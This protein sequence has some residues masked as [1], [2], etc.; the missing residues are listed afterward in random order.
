MKNN[1]T[2]LGR[3]NEALSQQLPESTSIPITDVS[4]IGPFDNTGYKGL[5]T[6]YDV[7][8]N[9]DMNKSYQGRDGLIDWVSMLHYSG[10]ENDYMDL[11]MSMPSSPWSVCYIVATIDSPTDQI[12]QLSLEVAGMCWA[13][14]NDQLILAPTVARQCNM[15]EDTLFV[16]LKKGKNILL[17]KAHYGV[18]PWAFKWQC[19][20]FGDMENVCDS[21]SK[22]TESSDPMIALTAKYTL[23]EIYAA[24]DIDKKLLETTTAI[25]QDRTATIWDKT[26]VKTLINQ[27]LETGSYL[28]IRD[29]KIDYKP[30]ENITPCDTLWPQVPETSKE[31]FVLDTSNES[32]QVE[33]ACKILQG[34][35]NR[36][37]PSLYITHTMYAKHDRQW[38]DEL[39]LE[40]YTSTPIS[41]EEAWKKYSSCIK[42]A[43]IYDGD[44]MDEIGEFRSHMLNQTNVLMMIASLED[45]IPI[46]PEM[47]EKLKLPVIFD[48]RGKWNSQFEMMNWAYRE[49]YPK[50]NQ[51]ILATLYPGKF[52][53]MDYLVA[54]KIFT[55]WFPE[56]RTVPEENLLNGILAST[57]PNTPIIGWWFD[58]MPNPKDENHKNADALQELNGLLHGSYFG[59][60]LTP[61]HEATNLTIHSGVAIEPMKHKKIEIPEYDPSKIYYTYML[62]DGDNLGEA[63]MIRTRDLHW[64]KKER[65]KVPVGWSFAPACAVMAPPVLNYYMRTLKE[66][67]LL[68]GGLGV[69]YTEP[70]IYLRAYLNRR[71]ELFEEYGRMTD[72]AMKPL[73][74]NC[75]WLINGLPEDVDIYA[76]TADSNIKGIFTGYGA[77]PE[78]ACARIAPNDVVAFRPCTRND[79]EPRPR[80]VHVENMVEDIKETVKRGEKF[81]EAWVLNWAFSMD[82]LLEVDDILGNDYVCVR[83]DVLVELRRKHG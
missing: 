82:M 44:I 12:A 79:E 11:G 41:L 77:G 34:I 71:I 68:V 26:W 76:R 16:S 75:L 80:E 25:I 7:E 28:P 18:E 30:I 14:L 55:F 46:T 24:F 69:G 17:L 51:T 27:K 72:A 74:A 6:T 67:D 61:S 23:A 60:I 29:L 8:T 4:A 58:W 62:S 81:I 73:D 59:K 45:A 38:M 57:P 52:F 36:E 15:L 43:I 65:G 3:W 5:L 21:I 33:F 1:K 32:P 22:L 42:G 56:H 49:L 53:L 37:K 54:F 2:A 13:W 19:T 10:I 40:G 63:L 20:G 50:M 64:D 35:A 31:L 78:M 9:L 39:H 48:A 83:P 70:T 47:N 66:A